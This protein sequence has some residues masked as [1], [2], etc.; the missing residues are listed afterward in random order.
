MSEGGRTRGRGRSK[1]ERPSGFLSSGPSDEKICIRK[2]SFL[3]LGPPLGASRLAPRVLFHLPRPNAIE[4]RT[5]ST[6]DRTRRH[7]RMIS[8]PGRGRGTRRRAPRPP[9]RESR[10]PPRRSR[11]P[12]ASA[13]ARRPP[14]RRT[15]APRR[16]SAAN[17]A[18]RVR[19]PKVVYTSRRRFFFASS[20]TVRPSRRRVCPTL[21]SSIRRLHSPPRGLP[22]RGARRGFS[23]RRDA[24]PPPSRGGSSSVVRAVVRSRAFL[25]VR[26]ALLLRL[27]SGSGAARGLGAPGR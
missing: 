22:G 2:D 14:R 4:L 18:S 10:P 16:A 15:D 23:R 1:E 3:S 21:F 25:F 24:A 17:E 11:R 13:R 5:R 12:C 6:F 27:R 19:T 8:P 26:R 7:L 9:A 20:R